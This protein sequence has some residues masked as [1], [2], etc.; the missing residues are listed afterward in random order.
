MEIKNMKALVTGASSGLGLE[1]CKLLAQRGYDIVGVS[2]HEG[3]FAKLKD[4]FKE[5]KFEFISFDLSNS[6]NVKSLIEKTKDIDFDYFYDNAGFGMI[7]HFDDGNIE[8]EMKMVDVNVKAAHM[9]LKEFVTRFYKKDKGNILVTASAAAFAPAP[10]MTPYYSTKAYMYYLC[11]GYWRELKERKSKV[12]LSVLCPGPVNTNFEKAGNVKFNIKP[13][14][15]EK[16]AA[17]AVKKSL[18][19]KTVIVP[20]FKIKLLHFFSHLFPKKFI[21]KVIKKSAD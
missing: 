5:R 7:G 13:I 21:T 1:V 18:K 3:E 12:K 15:C 19:G 17:Y 10:Y 11:L 16:C 6:N 14:S 20:S 4:D 2:R 9:L 8:K